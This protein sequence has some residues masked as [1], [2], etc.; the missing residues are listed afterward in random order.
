MNKKLIYKIVILKNNKI[1]LFSFLIS[2]G[3]RP[4]KPNHFSL[5]QYQEVVDLSSPFVVQR[6]KYF[7]SSSP[8]KKRKNSPRI[9]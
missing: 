2:Y 3:M 4:V 6:R 9:H 8:K 1:F 7:Q 5:V